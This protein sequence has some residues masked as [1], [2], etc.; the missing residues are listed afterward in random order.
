[1]APVKTAQ[2]SHCGLVR[3]AMLGHGLV[4]G[5]SFAQIDIHL[6][7]AATSMWGSR[8]RQNAWALVITN[9]ML[10]SI[11]VCDTIAVVPEY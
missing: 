6:S 8:A 7:L 3:D 10:R 11:W 9:I 4:L 5:T 2:D 1:M